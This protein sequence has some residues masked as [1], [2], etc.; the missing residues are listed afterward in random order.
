MKESEF[1]C[2][3]ILTCAVGVLIAGCSEQRVIVPSQAQS[4]IS[5]SSQPL[6]AS[7]YD[8]LY[9][10]QGNSRSEGDGD[11]PLSGVIAVSATLYG[12][13][14]LGGDENFS[15]C[16]GT[17]F[18]AGCGTVF[19]TSTSGEEHVLYRFA[20]GSDGFFPLAS[21]LWYNGMLYGTTAAGGGLPCKKGYFR[22]CGTVFALSLAGKERVLH[23]FA[24][25]P[26][27]AE[28]SANLTALNGMLYGTTS[29]GGA[30]GPGCDRSGGCGVV[31]Q[32]SPRGA[33]RVIYTFKGGKDG[34]IP[35]GPL[36]ALNGMLYGVTSGDEHSCGT[37]Y[38]LSTS[39]SKSIV[40][41][42]S[43]A[44]NGCDPIG[45][46]VALN[47]LLYGVTSWGGS[48][49]RG[50]VF[51]V[52]AGGAEN[53]IYSF[54]GGSDGGEPLAG[55]I[56][57][58]GALYG[59]TA[60]GGGGCTASLGCGTVFTLR[61]LGFE[62]VLHA[63]QAGDDGADPVAPVLAHGGTLYG[64]TA[65]GGGDSCGYAGSEDCGTVFKIVP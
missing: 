32:I 19:K 16:G 54:T 13:T 5:R 52:K 22:T 63:F 42:F 43:G 25:P 31:F 24:G 8:V 18:F 33:E 53:V 39:G 36:L 15:A 17:E 46:L 61:T 37:I 28:P 59:T 21:L 40:Y 2:Y 12:T 56:A 14:S 9:R 64:T 41:N 1:R 57:L 20:G 58:H 45:G 30:L 49:D 34:A 3:A 29:I 62:Q 35:S 50:T 4:A 55:L 48:Y 44:A 6:S 60:S 23:R 47:G 38:K 51:Q 65:L 26:D 10:F 27:G 11:V 7:G